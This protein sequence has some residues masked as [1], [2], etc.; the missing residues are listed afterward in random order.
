MEI[1]GSNPIGVAMNRPA[2]QP[3]VAVRPWCDD[4]AASLSA[5]VTESVEHLRPW[6]PWVASEPLSLEQ[7]R[8]QIAQW[9]ADGR[10]GGDMVFG[11]FVGDRVV[12]GCGLHRRVGPSAL[13]IGYWVHTAYTRR[14]YATHAAIVLTSLAFSFAGIEHVEIR[15]DAA[16][17]VS[18]AVPRK[19]GYML[20]A[21]VPT[22]ALAPA[23]TGVHD[24]WRMQRAEWFM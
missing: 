20:V 8:A 13:A 3:Q 22:P 10:A 24:V 18:A 12:G 19:L 21:H 15:V 14:G 16:N 6:M 9:A 23:E 7:R 2:L 17:E 11:I 5:A 4:D 1:V